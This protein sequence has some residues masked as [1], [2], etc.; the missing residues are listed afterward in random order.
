MNDVTGNTA[1]DVTRGSTVLRTVALVK[2]YSEGPAL[3][4]VLRGVDLDIRR[5][6]I[7]AIVGA[8]GAGKSTLLNLLGGLD[9]PTSG[10]V[11][12][13][14][15]TLSSLDEKARGVLRNRAIGFVYQFH[16][17]LPE[18]TARENV[19]MP[20][21]IGGMSPRLAGQRADALL[22]RVR[23][24]PRAEH[25]PGELSGG[26]RQRVAIARALVGN[27]AVVLADEPTGN[28]DRRTAE[29]VQALMFELNREL[30]ISFL[31]VTHDLAL[32]ARCHRVLELRDGLL[33]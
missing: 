1:A 7:V 27:P 6:E 25:K 23:L 20:L 33:V 8:S 5:G 16:H 28:L 22:A 32:A 19:A 30:A 13:L 24:A 9:H 12:V 21:L 17:L 4:E 18:F 14:G 26:E 10:R 31:L 29:E 3:V 2:H 15:E 11:D